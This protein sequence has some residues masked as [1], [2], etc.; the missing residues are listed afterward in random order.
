M[1]KILLVI[2]MCMLTVLLSAC[3]CNCHMEPELEKNSTLVVPPHFGN[4]PK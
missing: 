2:N 1:K 4:M 3:A